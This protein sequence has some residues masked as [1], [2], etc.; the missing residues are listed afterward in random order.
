MK[1]SIEDK[2]KEIAQSNFQQCSYVFDD[3]YSA[4]EVV[5]RVEFPVIMSI[6]PNGGRLDFS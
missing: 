4:T 6:L 5:D 1:M 2:I 3:W